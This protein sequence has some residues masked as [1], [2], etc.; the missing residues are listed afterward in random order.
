MEIYKQL[1]DTGFKPIYYNNGNLDGF[2]IKSRLN[3]RKMLNLEKYYGVVDLIIEYL[4]RDD[5]F[6]L[7]DI[8]STYIE[9]D[10][11]LECAELYWETQTGKDAIDITDKFKDI[12]KLIPKEYEDEFLE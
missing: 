11:K 4:G 5:Y 10:D 3:Y 7:N 9:V 2:V 8:E 1:L 12:L 6:W